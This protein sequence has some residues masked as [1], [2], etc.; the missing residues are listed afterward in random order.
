M[1]FQNRPII[2]PPN[3]R[4]IVNNPITDIEGEDTSSKNE[5]FIAKLGAF[6]GAL[7]LIGGIIEFYASFLA[8]EELQREV[9]QN[10]NNASK[11]G[12]VKTSEEAR[13]KELEMQVN[14]LM[15]EIQKMK[16]TNQKTLHK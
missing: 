15:K 12:S 6:G 7:S 2:I 16:N 9:Y 3:Q 4:P 13:I 10:Y 14:Y 5:L 8:L 1:Q 11:D